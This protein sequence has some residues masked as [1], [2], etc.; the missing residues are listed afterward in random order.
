MQD[1]PIQILEVEQLASRM[2]VEIL[3]LIVPVLEQ[4]DGQRVRIDSGARSAKWQTA[5]SKFRDDCDQVL[6][7]FERRFGGLWINDDHNCV[8]INIKASIGYPAPTGPG[9]ISVY[10]QRQHY[11]GT[12]EN[13]LLKPDFDLDAAIKMNEPIIAAKIED[14]EAAAVECNR[15]EQLREAKRREIPFWLH[16]ALGAVR[17]QQGI[18]L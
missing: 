3:P 5:I 8:W 16:D 9:E 13:Q 17:V 18:A 2:A 11:L 4:F 1:S 10:R 12:I 14:I 6:G 15:L 7:G